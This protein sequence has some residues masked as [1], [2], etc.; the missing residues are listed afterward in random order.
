MTKHRL[1][2]ANTGGPERSA[3]A[4]VAVAAVAA[5][6]AVVAV[7]AVAAVVAVTITAVVLADTN[8]ICVFLFNAERSRTCCKE[9]GERPWL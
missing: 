7:V 1:F 9:A 4:I 8:V 5:V 2:V 3:C 6:V